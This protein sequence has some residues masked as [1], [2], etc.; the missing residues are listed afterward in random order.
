MEGVT[1]MATILGLLKCMGMLPGAGHSP[2]HEQHI[3]DHPCVSEEGQSEWAFHFIFLWVT[4][5]WGLQDTSVGNKLFVIGVVVT[6]GVSPSGV[7]FGL[8]RIEL[9]AKRNACT[10]PPAT[11]DSLDLLKSNQGSV[12]I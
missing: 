3:P 1:D 12:L 10:P 9:M 5:R 2:D 6:V 11:Q 4:R 7:I 8:R